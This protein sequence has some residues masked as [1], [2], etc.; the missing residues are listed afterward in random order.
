MACSNNCANYFCERAVKP[1][2]QII[3]EDVVTC[4]LEDSVTDTPM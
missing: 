3:V 2:V 1:I 4:F